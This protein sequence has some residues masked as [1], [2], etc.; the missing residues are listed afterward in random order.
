MEADET[1]NKRVELKY[2]IYRDHGL[3]VIGIKP[4]DLQNIDEAMRADLR[5]H[6]VPVPL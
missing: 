2:R 5:R 3:T 4:A 1:Y 6:R